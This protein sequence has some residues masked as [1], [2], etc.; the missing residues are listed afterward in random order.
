MDEFARQ[1]YLEWEAKKVSRERVVW[2]HAIVWGAV[3]LLLFV[4]WAVT[5]AGFPWFIFPL[6]GWFIGLA[7][8]AAT[9]YVLRGPDDVIYQREARRRRQL[10]A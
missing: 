3:N 2:G 9:V 1:A 8:H 7:A 5:G 6:L 4:I 10:G